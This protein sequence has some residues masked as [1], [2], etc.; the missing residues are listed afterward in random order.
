[1]DMYVTVSIF[2]NIITHF[3]LF[4]QLSVT[5]CCF[6]N[7]SGT[8]VVKVSIKLILLGPINGDDDP[9][10][11]TVTEEVMPP[12]PATPAALMNPATVVTQPSPRP[13][14]DLTDENKPAV[15]GDDLQRAIELSLAEGGGVTVGSS[16]A[17]SQE[18]QDVSKALEASLLESSRSRRKTDSQNP[19][20]KKRDGEASNII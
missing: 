1:M 2:K 14:V 13:V 4:F 19:H 9:G 12:S 7:I 15:G 20:D 3:Q 16:S 17:F 18:E 11:V 10:L 8:Y 6:P 5:F